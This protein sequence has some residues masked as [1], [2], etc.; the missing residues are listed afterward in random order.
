MSGGRVRVYAS[1]RGAV[2]GRPLRQTN[3][4][5]QE[6]TYRAGTALLEFSRLPAEFVIEVAR[7]PHGRP[8]AARCIPRR[9]ARLPLRRGR[10]RQSRHDAD[11]RPHRRAPAPRPPDHA[12]RVPAARSTACCASRRWQDGADL[13]NSDRYFDG[14]AYL[15]AAR[16]AGGVAALNRALVREELRPGDRPRRFRISRARRGGG[17]RLARAARRRSRGAG[18][19]GVQDARNPRGEEDRH[20]GRGEGGQRRARLAARGLRVRGRAQ[21]PGHAGDQ[22]GAHRARQAAHATSG[23]TFSSPGS[24][25]SSTRRTPTIGKIDHASSQL[26]LLANMPSRAIRRGRRSRRRS[27]TT[28]APTCSTP[29]RSSTRTSAPTSRSPTT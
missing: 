13:R 6:R 1:E 19:G 21:G 8:E 24:A 16:R 14:D 4:N 20:A 17:R 28:S 23:P 25:P 15:R 29:R 18:Q 22:A 27:S 5:R 7:R 3:G 26:A 10:A 11:R 9:R 12:V 2:A